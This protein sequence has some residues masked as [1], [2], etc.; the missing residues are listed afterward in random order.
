M[1]NSPRKTRAQEANEKGEK[2]LFAWIDS[3]LKDWFEA[4]CETQRRSLKVGLEMMIER[5][6]NRQLEKT[7]T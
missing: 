2:S 5:E 7:A 1:K 4:S 6:R 3:D